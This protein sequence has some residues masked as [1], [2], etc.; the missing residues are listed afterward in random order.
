MTLLNRTHYLQCPDDPRYKVT[1]SLVGRGQEITGQLMISCQVTDLS[2]PYYQALDQQQGP[3][4]THKL[5][6]HPIPEQT[7]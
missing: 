6:L 2:L 3:R 4:A 1:F 5:D 7:T